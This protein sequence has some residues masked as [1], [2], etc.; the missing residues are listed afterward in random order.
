LLFSRIEISI[1][2][3]RTTDSISFIPWEL[4]AVEKFRNPRIETIRGNKAQN[5]DPLG[6]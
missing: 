5:A 3:S 6:E 1:M 4:A 2:I